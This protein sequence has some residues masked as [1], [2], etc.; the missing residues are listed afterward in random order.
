MVYIEVPAQKKG[1]APISAGHY[2]FFPD[3]NSIISL[4]DDKW[5]LIDSG[6]LR[7]RKKNIFILMQKIKDGK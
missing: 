6:N 4:F 2:S 7:K 1:D 5:V 3:L